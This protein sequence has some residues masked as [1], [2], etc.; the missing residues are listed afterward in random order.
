MGIACRMGEKNPLLEP[1]APPTS[2]LWKYLEQR[3]KL[4]LMSSVFSEKSNLNSQVKSFR[5]KQ[6]EELPRTNNADQRSVC[7]FAAHLRF[8]LANDW[9]TEPAAWESQ[10]LKRT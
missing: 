8:C 9:S 10:T 5:T 4:T 6:K 1:A 2:Q 7:T 3:D